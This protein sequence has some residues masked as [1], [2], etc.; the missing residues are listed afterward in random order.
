MGE[1][2]DEALDNVRDAIGLWIKMARKKGQPVPED[3]TV[4]SKV[5]VQV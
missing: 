4:V 5:T 2:I 3:F 1:T